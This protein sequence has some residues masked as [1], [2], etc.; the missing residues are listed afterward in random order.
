M[1]LSDYIEEIEI[2]T[3]VTFQ[4]YTGAYRGVVYGYEPDPWD[5]LVPRAMA[6]KSENFFEGLQFCGGYSSRCSGYGGSILSGRAA[7]RRTMEAM[8]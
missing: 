4:R 6:L 7:A 1:N 5:S 8:D 3:P 2:A